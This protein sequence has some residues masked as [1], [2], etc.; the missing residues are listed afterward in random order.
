MAR[1]DKAYE[2]VVENPNKI[3]DMCEYIRPIPKG[4]FPPNIEGAQNSLLTLH[5]KEQKR[6]TVIHCLKS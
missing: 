3:A 4:T 2:Y 1:K 6:N 5:G